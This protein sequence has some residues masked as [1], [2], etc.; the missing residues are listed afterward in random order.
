MKALRSILFLLLISLPAAQLKAINSEHVKAGVG[1]AFCVGGGL[2]AMHFFGKA[3]KAR[4]EKER[5]WYRFLGYCSVAGS[6]AGGVYCVHKL[7][8]LSKGEKP[9]GKDGDPLTRAEKVEKF[10]EEMI[11]KYADRGKKG[12]LDDMTKKG[13]SGLTAENLVRDVE[14]FSKNEVLLTTEEMYEIKKNILDLWNTGTIDTW[15]HE[16]DRRFY[17]SILYK[18]GLSL[19]SI[20]TKEEVII[21]NEKLEAARLLE[22]KKKQ[23]AIEKDIEENKGFDK[24]LVAFLKSGDKG[25]FSKFEVDEVHK[26][27]FVR[28]IIDDLRQKVFSEQD[29][30]DKIC[31]KGALNCTEKRAEK[32]LNGALET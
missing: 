12:I 8:N 11:K 19:N 15:N 6:I 27:K 10:K 17:I 26:A 30:I 31:C 32:I 4:S 5:D 20:L 1:A 9:G 24:D 22:E 18:N 28:K 13:R 2:A 23:D 29:A 16:G 3:V 21:E 14:G 25:I 7:W